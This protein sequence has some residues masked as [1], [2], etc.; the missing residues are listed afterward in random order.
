[1]QVID[2]RAARFHG[3]PAIRRRRRCR[4]CGARLTTFEM[5]ATERTPDIPMSELRAMVL[6]LQTALDI[7]REKVANIEV[8]QNG[9]YIANPEA[10][11]KDLM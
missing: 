4:K 11:T 7:I 3:T 8:F 2:S 9:G 5:V 10:S 1:M 6:V